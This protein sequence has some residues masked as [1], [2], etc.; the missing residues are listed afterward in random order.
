M[1]Y[2]ISFQFLRHKSLKYMD[3]TN[4]K[5]LSFTLQKI[6]FYFIVIFGMN[7]F[8]HG[9]AWHGLLILATWTFTKKV[10]I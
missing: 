1:E 10:E 7:I 9:V 3:K 5:D 4:L 2:F 8:W 6:L